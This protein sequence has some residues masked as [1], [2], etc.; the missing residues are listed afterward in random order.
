[1]YGQY[2][3][4]TCVYSAKKVKYYKSTWHHAGSKTWYAYTGHRTCEKIGGH[5]SA[6]KIWA[7][8]LPCK[9]IWQSFSRDSVYAYQDFATRKNDDSCSITWLII[10]L[11]ILYFSHD[12]VPIV[13]GARPED[14]E[15]S[16]PYYSFI[17]VDDFEDAKDLAKYLHKLDE[18]DELYNE[19]FKWKVHCTL[20]TF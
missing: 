15:R 3:S 4:Y 8:K 14:Y 17:H 1:M 19:Y 9:Q 16:A 18:D 6:S 7:P 20:T 5:F 2:L 10:V 12:I 13:M 11:L